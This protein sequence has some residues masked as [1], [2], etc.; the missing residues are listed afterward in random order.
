MKNRK[1]QTLAGISA[2]TLNTLLLKAAKPMHIKAEGGGLLK[3]ILLIIPTAVAKQPFLHSDLFWY[4]FH[5]LTGGTMVILYF[6][7]FNK[8]LQTQ[9]MK[10][11]LFSLFPWLINGFVVL[12]LL[13]QGMLGINSLPLSGILYFFAA[14]LLFGIALSTAYKKFIG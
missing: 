11:T 8:L 5:Y 4:I 7:F 6:V 12:P 9:I 3:L 14:N 10:G 1:A 13:N 2:I